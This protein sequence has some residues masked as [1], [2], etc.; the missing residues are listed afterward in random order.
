MQLKSLLLRPGPCL[1]T[2]TQCCHKNFS[3]WECS[4]LWKLHCQWLKFL[5]Q[6]QI[7]V[8][9]QGPG[10]FLNIKTIFPGY[11]DSHVEDNRLIFNMGI[12]ILVRQHLYTYIEMAPWRTILIGSSLVQLTTC[13]LCSIKPLPEPMTYYHLA[14]RGKLQWNF[15]DLQ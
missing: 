3:Q 1:T 15:K 2:A 8:V 9:R 13:H 4:F 10:P 7:A 14:L 12:P 6:R 11:R 5:W